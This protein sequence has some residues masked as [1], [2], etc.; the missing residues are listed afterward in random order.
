[1]AIHHD[2]CLMNL[3]QL[4]LNNSQVESTSFHIWENIREKGCI[5]KIFRFLG[6]LQLMHLKLDG[7][8]EF[9]I[10]RIFHLYAGAQHYCIIALGPYMLAASIVCSKPKC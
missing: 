6:P 3:T 9:L 2:L 7:I 8:Y 10:T 5:D 4:H 1:M